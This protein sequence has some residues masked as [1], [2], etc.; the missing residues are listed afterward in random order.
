MV[1]NIEVAGIGPVTVHR[2]KGM[3]SIRISV[4]QTGVVKLSLPFNVSL[5]K[6]LEFLQTKKD[7]VNKNAPEPLALDDGAYIG[8][9]YVLRLHIGSGSKIKSVR[10]T[11][12]L[13]IYVPENMDYAQ[14]QTKLQN[15]AKKLL[16][17][18]AE[19]LLLPRLQLFAKTG[20]YKIKTSSIALLK[21]RWGSC[22]S[23]NDIVLNGYLVQ[24]PLSY[25]D[26]VIWHELA[27]TKHHNHGDAFWRQV[28]IHVPDY[29]TIRKALKKYPTAV[30][31]SREINTVV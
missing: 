24:L 30:F 17:E 9:G 26:Y 16:I 13:H 11:N 8:R 19:A 18:Q 31:D 15:S 21:S 4:A 1:Q 29:K 25:I 27:H 28:Q 3:R 22:S 2:R 6:G 5:Q 12:E 14:V 20:D 23:A 7:W 10:K